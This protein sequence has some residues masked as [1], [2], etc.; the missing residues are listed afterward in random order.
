MRLGLYLKIMTEASTQPDQPGSATGAHRESLWLV[1]L[2]ETEER[3]HELLERLHALGVETEE[4]SIVRVELN[5][6][7]RASGAPASAPPLSQRQRNA[8]TGAIIGSAVLLVAG[9][10]LYESGL[11][12]FAALGALP[13]H[14]LLFVITGA[15]LGALFGVLFISTKSP[16]LP[17]TASTQ[18]SLSQHS[19]S[20]N[21][22]PA[23][24]DL[25][26][27]GYLVAVKMPPRLGEQAE[28]IARGLG[29]K[30][31]LL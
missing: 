5:D 28:A 7:M 25:A 31:I 26:S 1:A 15:L 10:G 21:N 11:L 24:P 16:P 4:A 22:A 12:K 19:R 29:A 30:Q 27:D 8:I 20:P 14:A 2:Y 18:N 6:Q 17:R 3:I 9:M 13:A 23:M